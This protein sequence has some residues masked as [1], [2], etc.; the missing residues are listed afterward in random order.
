MILGTL[1]LDHITGKIE[2]RKDAYLERIYYAHNKPVFAIE[3]NSPKCFLHFK[4]K[5]VLTPQQINLIKNGDV[6]LFTVNTHESFHDAVTAVYKEIIECD[7]PPSNVVF[8]NE[9]A[10]INEIVAREAK[11]LNVDKMKSI[12]TRR[13]EYDVQRS[14]YDY[15]TQDKCC[16]DTLMDKHYEK[17]YLLLNRRWRLHRPTLVGLLHNAGYLN[18]GYV[19]MA[20]S[21]D[22]KGWVKFWRE[23]DYMKS[24]GTLSDS[25]YNDLKQNEESISQLSDMYLDTTDLV[26]NRA[27]LST[28]V[29]QFYNDTYFSVVSETNYFTSDKFEHASG[30]F[31]S[32]KVFKCFSHKHPFVMVS[33]PGFLAV[34]REQGYKTFSPY[35]DETYDTIAD[36]SERMY[37]IVREI[38]RLCDLPPEQLSE[39]L[40]AMKEICEHNYNV[41]MAK[42][43]FYT[44]FSDLDDPSEEY[45]KKVYRPDF[46]LQSEE[47]IISEINTAIDNGAKRIIFNNQWESL[48]T[49]PPTNSFLTSQDQNTAEGLRNIQT[50][51]F[52]ELTKIHDMLPHFNCKAR[53]ITMISGPENYAAVYA[54]Y[55]KIFG[56]KWHEIINI[57][58]EPYWEKMVG[59]ESYLETSVDQKTYE[60]TKKYLL[61]NRMPH[62]HRLILVALLIETGEINDGL[63]SLY[64]NLAEYYSLDDILSSCSVSH[65][66]KERVKHIINKHD[67]LF[68][69]RL[70]L[71]E[72]ASNPVASISEEDY[73]AYQQTYFS[74]VTET[75][76][77]RR[78]K[79]FQQPKIYC[80]E[81]IYKAIRCKHPFVLIAPHNSLARLR[82]DGYMT[83]NDVINESYDSIP[84]DEERLLR[85]HQE[86]IRICMLSLEEL[87]EWRKK[88]QHVIDH[89]YN[90]LM[91][92][93]Y[94]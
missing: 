30:I 61:Y 80:S 49:A 50:H 87:A 62:V 45:E 94:I 35:I 86:I 7:I 41:F 38:E 54:E 83:F 67:D 79:I 48:Q 90:V 58:Y 23:W 24:N 43:K 13:F 66:L 36:D 57:R 93:T 2:N 42:N 74:V 18:K 78:H 75:N 81:K 4:L 28:T 89:N 1:F 20:P 22:K 17:K 68:P 70:T 73:K 52:P 72:H 12:W 76:F 14:R 26:T 46:L 71:D 59:Q 32:E 31:F 84:D 29:D 6:D 47:S 3:F 21:D 16:I 8:C 37:A 5:D 44:C 53:D 85:V 55:I 64:T 77:F 33:V 88:I 60:K 10:R 40:N 9:S 27:A 51:T 63:V 11:I 19:S 65:K 34:L 39:F 25:L 91:S 15:L 69:M 56:I 92:R 82:D